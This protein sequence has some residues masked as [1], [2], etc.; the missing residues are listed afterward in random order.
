MY[1]NFSA[2][3][4]V[5][6]HNRKRKVLCLYRQPSV[7][8][9][10]CN[11]GGYRKEIWKRS[12]N[13]SVPV[14][15]VSILYLKYSEGKLIGFIIEKEKYYASITNNHYLTHYKIMLDIESRIRNI[16]EIQWYRFYLFPSCFQILA[17]VLG[18]D[19]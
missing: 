18:L 16:Q 6:I 15:I 13:T 7:L 3:T 5:W 19:P 8:N 17:A 14:Y 2:G 9:L 10:I 1:L 11:K 12:T 4:T